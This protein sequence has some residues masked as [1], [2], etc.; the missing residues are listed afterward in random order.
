MLRQVANTFCLNRYF[1]FE[2]PTQT[3]MGARRFAKRDF[4]PVFELFRGAS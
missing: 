1:H 3:R 2:I 4:E